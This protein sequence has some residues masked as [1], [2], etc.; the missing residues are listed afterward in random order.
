MSKSARLVVLI[1]SLL[2]VLA[3]SAHAVT[4]HNSGDTTFTATTILPGFGTLSATG[5]NMVCANHNITGTTGAAPFVGST[6]T[7]AQW[8]SRYTTSS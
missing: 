2:A 8:T 1:V 3:P 6:W 4:W 7:A 5:I